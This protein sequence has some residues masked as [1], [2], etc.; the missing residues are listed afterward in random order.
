MLR[1]VHYILYARKVGV[2]YPHSKKWGYVYPYSP[3]SYTYADA[4]KTQNK[5]K[6]N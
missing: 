4:K 2:W 5:D 3:E 1:G 6:K